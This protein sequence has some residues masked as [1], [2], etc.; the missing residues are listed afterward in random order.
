MPHSRKPNLQKR[1]GSLP[2]DDLRCVLAI[3][4]SGSLNGA[5]RELGIEHSTVFRRLNAI[6]KRLGV[7]LFERS[8][9]GYVA[10]A[11]GE[12]AAAAAGTMELEALRIER[13]MMGADARLAGV[14]RLATSELFAGF[15]LPRLLQEFLADHPEMEVELDVSNSFAD[16]TRREADLALRA[17]IAPPEHLVGHHVGDLRYAVYGSAG[18]THS[19]T[20]QLETLPWLGFDDSIAFL[21]IARVQRALPVQNSARVRF[22]SIA[23]MLH[24]AAEGLGVAI[25]PLFAADRCPALAR[26]GPVL[27]HPRMK[28]WVL[29]HSEMRGNARVMALSRHLVKRI[30]AVLAE[31]QQI[32]AASA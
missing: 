6:E 11:Q 20:R 22:N 21:E 27:E 9:A 10:T 13:Q 24:A 31:L 7:R 28:L 5:A 29:N 25:L 18:L 2:W 14:V 23:S 19:N 8:K 15:L 16:L 3:A 32:R 26:W 4:R 17:T 30:P 12:L 1:T